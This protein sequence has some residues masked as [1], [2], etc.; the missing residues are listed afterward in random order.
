MMHNPW[1]IGIGD[2]ARLRKNADTLDKMKRDIVAL[3]SRRTGMDG[4]EISAL[5]DA[6]TWYTADEAVEAGFADSVAERDMDAAA[7]VF[8]LEGY[9]FHAVPDYLK[10]QSFRQ[11]A[12]EIE[13][14]RD[15]ERFLRDAGFSATQAKRIAV[16]GF[17]A[18]HRD[19]GEAGSQ[20]DVA[21]DSIDTLVASLRKNA[22]ILS[23]TSTHGGN[24]N[25]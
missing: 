1:G 7:K 11:K 13:T 12:R 8:D 16:S 15:F 14:E 22:A 17:K 3:Y 10:R 25:G 4:K 9:G 24:S 6:E 5:M 23:P 18:R 2:A 21:D 20:R 19:D